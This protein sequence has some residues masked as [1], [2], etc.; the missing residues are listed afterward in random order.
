MA[1]ARKSL[2]NVKTLGSLAEKRRVRTPSTALLELSVLANEKQRLHQE[3]A[4]MDRRRSEIDRRL[5][6]IKEKENRLQA[7]I[8]NP[9]LIGLVPSFQPTKRVRAKEFGY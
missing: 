6:E 4:A 7:F 5:D 1:I 8:G 9:S 3:T 2:R